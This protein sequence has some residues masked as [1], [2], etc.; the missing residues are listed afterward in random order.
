MQEK[1]E[2]K[3]KSIN[4]TIDIILSLVVYGPIVFYVHKLNKEKDIII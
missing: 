3:W 2:W 4:R 1:V